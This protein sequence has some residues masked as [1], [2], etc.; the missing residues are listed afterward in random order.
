LPPETLAQRLPGISETAKIFAGVD[1]TKEPAPVLPTVHYNMGGAPTNWKAQCIKPTANDPDALVPGLL[2]AGEASCASVHGANRLGANSLLDLVVFGR[3]AADT[4][5]EIV[6]PNS[7]QV[8]CPPGAGEQSIA[9]MDAILNRKSGIPTA[10]IRTELQSVMQKYAPVYRN[11][12][13]LRIGKTKVDEVMAKYGDVTV[14]DKTMIWN[15]DLMEAMELE[16]ILIQG[17]M[18]MHAAENREESRG[19]Q[20]REDFPDRDDVKWG[21]HT[22]IYQTDPITEKSKIKLDY[23]PVHEQPLDDQMHHVPP[24]KRVY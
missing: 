11:G 16:N 1:V 6:K 8:P 23:R 14:K 7:P 13:D 18:T 4:I 22:L 10:E 12:D 5:A 24:A 2:A 17:A 15:T 3:Q 9:R 21:K 20:A 19:A